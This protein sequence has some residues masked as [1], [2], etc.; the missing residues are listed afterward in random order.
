M[1]TAQSPYTDLVWSV[2]MQASDLQILQV[3]SL[4]YQESFDPAAS[5]TLHIQP[6]YLLAL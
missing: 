1:K 2:L 3:S 4:V 6:P 5:D